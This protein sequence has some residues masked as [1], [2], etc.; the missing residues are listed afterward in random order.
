MSQ[1]R[2]GWCVLLAYRS[3]EL[4]Q[5]SQGIHCSPFGETEGKEIS[6]YSF[7]ADNKEK[8]GNYC[9]L[10]CFRKIQLGARATGR[11]Q[12][13]GRPKEGRKRQGLATCLSISLE[14]ITKSW[15]QR[16]VENTGSLV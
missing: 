6:L 4:T 10:S 2:C 7:K 1:E 12:K 13:L 5:N 14:E 3:Q 16:G 11:Q 15:Q 9:F 8:L